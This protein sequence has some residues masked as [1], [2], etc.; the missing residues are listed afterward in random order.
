M[1]RARLLVALLSLLSL[2]SPLATARSAHA[3]N[4][5]AFVPAR[6]TTWTT[7]DGLPSDKVLCV[8]RDGGDVWAGTERG[9][10]RL[11]DGVW[12]SFG[13][14]DGLAHRVVTALALAEDT[15]DLWI[16]TLGGLS[17]WSGGCLDSFH[18]LDSGL[19][20]DVIYALEV[21]DGKVW[22]ATAAGVSVLEPRSGD[23]SLYDH[24]NTVMHEPWCYGLT[25]APGAMWVAVW[26]GGVVE[27][28]LQRGTWRA[29]RDPDGEM[30]ID[31]FRDDGLI[32]DV[33]SAVSF[34]EGVLWVGTYFGL[35][36]YDGRAWRS[37]LEHESP[38][39]SNFI[40]AVRAR[41]RVAWIGTDR[42]LAAFDGE[43]WIVC[44][45]AD[46]GGD[47][48]VV[49]ADG[50]ETRVPCEGALAH[51]YVLGLWV[52][53]DAVWVATAEGLSVGRRALTVGRG[54]DGPPAL[55]RLAASTPAVAS[56]DAA[57]PTPAVAP[58]PAA[59][60]TPAEA[61]APDH[62]S[63]AAARPRLAPNDHDPGGLP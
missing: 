22:V 26:G 6:W 24:E 39:P 3:G 20:N 59:A 50:S 23:W 61:L 37:W 10:A 58:T 5:G 17:R 15:G 16:G 32:H 60:P 42:G 1:P 18:Q 38:L 41:G 30:E 12:T 52:D 27:H 57:A 28:D 63:T 49:A 4:E 45:A 11:A 35:S 9:L 44:H 46:A 19:I 31:L 56:A 7:L 62:S 34:A 36:R 53:D 47:T 54:G 40:N 33:T 43:R 25:Q 2:L 21:M 13:T 14:D 55:D 29:Y 51:D 48:R 8:L